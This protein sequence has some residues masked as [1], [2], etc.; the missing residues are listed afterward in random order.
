MEVV[1]S[2][3][4]LFFHSEVTVGFEQDEYSVLEMAGPLV[5][6]AVLNG[7]TERNV[8]VSISTGSPQNEGEWYRPTFK[9][10]HHSI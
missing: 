1:R 9:I 3:Q 8:V 2:N 4:L 6:C 5:V 7:S 10:R